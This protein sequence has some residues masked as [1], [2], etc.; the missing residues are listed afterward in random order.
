[1][2]ASAYWG[3]WQWWQD[4]EV[5]DTDFYDPDLTG[6]ANDDD[7]ANF[8]PSNAVLSWVFAH[9]SCND[10]TNTGC[11]AD[12][13]CG[14]NAY[15]PNF[16]LSGANE[17][18]CISKLPRQILT[19]STNNWHGNVVRYGDGAASLAL[20]ES[21]SSGGWD[22]A[23]TNGGTNI[24]LITNSCG[25]RSRYILGSSVGDQYLFAGMHE[26]FVQM[27]VGNQFVPGGPAITSDT[28][29][30]SARG[31]TMA[32]LILTNTNAV[33]SVAW[34]TPSFVDNEYSGAGANV[35]KAK[36]TT[37][38]AAQARLST[39]TWYQSISN[40][41]DATSYAHEHEVYACNFSNCSSY[42]L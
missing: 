32:N 33:A 42:S 41:L 34:L 29:Q 31:S 7:T 2:I 20:G 12:S 5:Y 17:A 23:G 9:G 11:R 39:E 13:D 3:P 15:C 10:A 6:G 25:F 40:S 37:A 1:M 14:S 36:D 16:P 4:N 21:P 27:P 18:A 28:Y 35:V 24:T 19:S 22:G 30:W 8:D 38:A 26:L